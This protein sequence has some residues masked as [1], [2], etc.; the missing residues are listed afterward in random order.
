MLVVL[1]AL[2]ATGC[3]AKKGFEKEGFAF[4]CP[5]GDSKVGS[6]EDLIETKVA[7]EGRR[8]NVIVTELRCTMSGDLMKIEANLNNDAGQIRRVA[9]KFRWMDREG[10]RVGE[11]EAWKPVLMYEKSNN[12]VAALA[13]S[14][15]AAD[16]RLIVMGQD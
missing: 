4:G 5:I 9:Y 14:G 6:M 11:E 16:F 12:V 7:Q 13:P 1:V 2:L 3:A 8:T 10:M 15:R